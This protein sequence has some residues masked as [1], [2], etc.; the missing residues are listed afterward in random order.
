VGGQLVTVRGNSGLTIVFKGVTI[1]S[2][3]RE[4][5]PE[6]LWIFRSALEFGCSKNREYIGVVETPI[7]TIMKCF[8][9]E[10]A[11]NRWLGLWKS[12]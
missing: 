1:L 7:K 11:M 12:S 6:E 10:K 5:K 8:N 4:V 9:N 3:S 2:K